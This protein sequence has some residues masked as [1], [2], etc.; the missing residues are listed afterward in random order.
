V[1]D[2]T[3]RLLNATATGD[4]LIF[5]EPQDDLRRLDWFPGKLAWRFQQSAVKVA[6]LAFAAHVEWSIRNGVGIGRTCEKFDEMERNEIAVFAG[7]YRA[8]CG[9]EYPHIAAGVSIQRYGDLGPS[10]HLPKRHGRPV[11]RRKRR[12]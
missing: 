7:E 4:R 8:Q 1:R 9:K 3:T 10:K 2:S 5:E 6:T 12:R 11:L